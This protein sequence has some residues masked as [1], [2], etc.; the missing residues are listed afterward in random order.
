MDRIGQCL[1][2]GWGVY[3]HGQRSVFVNKNNPL[4]CSRLA[5][6]QS[7]FSNCTSA[8]RPVGEVTPTDSPT[9]PPYT[10]PSATLARH[11]FQPIRPLRVS[12]VIGWLVIRLMSFKQ[13]SSCTLRSNWPTCVP[14]SALLCG[15]LLSEMK[16]PKVCKSGYLHNIV[17][18][19]VPWNKYR[20]C[21]LIDTLYPMIHIGSLCKWAVR[22]VFWLV[23]VNR[24]LPEFPL[25]LIP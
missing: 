14:Q 17:H 16:C 4:C 10:S 1:L 3:T 24:L 22:G 20:W 11:R 25:I 6:L 18:Y 23:Y 7:T 5:K 13:S 15:R 12:A 8:K 21:I 9:T 2:Y 19:N